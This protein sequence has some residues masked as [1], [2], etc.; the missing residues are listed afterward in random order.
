AT[1]STPAPEATVPAT[2]TVPRVTHIDSVSAD[3]DLNSRTAVYRDDV[4]VTDADMKLTCMWLTAN[5]PQS[6]RMNHIVARTNVVIDFTDTKGETMRA[7]ADQ[8]VYDYREENGV[9]NE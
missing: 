4:R 1:H 9:T 8:A 5:L 7:T 2:T 3:F 6:G